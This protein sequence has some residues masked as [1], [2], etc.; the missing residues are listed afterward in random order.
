MANCPNCQIHLRTIREIEGLYY[1]CDQCG[2]RAETMQ[3]IRRTVGDR[4]IS[5]MVRRVNT[6]T[7]ISPRACPFCASPMKLLQLPNP[8]LAL[9]S[10]RTCSMIWFDAGKFEQ[11][12]VGAVDTPEDAM[13]RALEAEAK[14][15]MEQAAARSR[16][17]YGQGAPDEWWKWIFAVLGL[18][19][20][21]QSPEVSKRPWATW[22]LAAVITVVS[23]IAFSNLDDAVQN[24]GFIPAERWRYGGITFLTSFFLHGGWGHLLGNMYFFLLFSA[25]VEEYLGHWRF[26]ALT[27]LSALAGSLFQVIGTPHLMEPCVGASG[28]ISGVMVFYALKF[29]RGTLAFFL[30]RLGWLHLPAWFAFVLWLLLQAFQYSLQRQGFSFDNVSYLDHFGGVTTGF[31]LWLWWRKLKTDQAEVA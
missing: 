27:L 24:F 7:E 15:K 9:E 12:P 28:G 3:Q 5:G 23:V 11:L 18:P 20:K 16:G 14:W 31:L 1:R 22:S 17:L 6:A 26:L 8:P 10:C 30:W 25:E 21:S 13:G 19:V 4:Y 29:P 2:G